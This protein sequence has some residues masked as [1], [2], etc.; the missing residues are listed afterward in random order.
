MTATMDSSPARRPLRAVLTGAAALSLCFLALAWNLPLRQIDWRQP[1]AYSDDGLVSAM[2]VKAVVDNGWYLH[3]PRLGAPEGLDLSDFPMSDNRFDVDVDERCIRLLALFT[4][5]YAL[6]ANS[7]FLLTFPLTVLTS[8]LVL[9]H[10]GISGGPAAAASVLFAFLP[11]HFFRGTHH[12]WLA[13]YYLVPPVVMVCLWVFPGLCSFRRPCS[14]TWSRR[15]WL[16]ALAICG[17][18]SSAGVYYA[19]FGVFLLGV[20]GLAAAWRTRSWAPLLRSLA[21]IAII[22][23]GVLANLLPTFWR[24]WHHG[25]STDSLHR[26]LAQA[27]YHGLKLSQLLLPV[28]EHPARALAELR[29]YYRLSTPLVNENDWTSLGLAGSA[30][31]LLLLCRLAMR[32]P[33]AGRPE[34]AD[35]LA[36]LN[37]A[38]FLL[39]TV[40]GLGSLIALFSPL[41]R[42]YNRIAVY[43]AFLSL[44][45]LALALDRWVR[46]RHTLGG[47]LLGRAVLALVLVGG[48]WD[49]SSRYTRLIF[50][51]PG[52]V[53]ASNREF[54]HAVESVLPAESLVF[55]LP[56][57]AFPESGRLH[58]MADYD[59]LRPYLHSRTLRWSHGAMSGRVG[60]VWQRQVTSKAVPEMLHDL[61]VAGFAGLYVDRAG[62]ADNATELESGLQQVLA[63]KPLVSRDRRLAFYDLREYSGQARA[64]YSPERLLEEQERILKPLV[65]QWAGGF[66]PLETDGNQT[67]RW[68]GRRGTLHI[69]NPADR[70]RETTL[71]FE[72]RSTQEEPATLRIEG[73]LLNE[74]LEVSP[75][76]IS[77]ART[78][79][80]PP[81]HHVL[82]FTCRGS[83]LRTPYD[84]RVLVFMVRN[85]R[86]M[87]AAVAVSAP[88]LM[89]PAAI[90]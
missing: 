58:N 42:A 45:M 88:F 80:V 14:E 8:L 2:Y 3:N 30:G 50:A 52:A 24:Q 16:A 84:A 23:V 62:F 11:Y 21:C 26:H 85:F 48:I 19:F 63:V 51:P 82:R 79:V 36:I 31:F 15:R 44:F 69:E 47:R 1:L 86:T 5:D 12:L 68:C 28:Y 70:P 73:P 67:W 89:Q 83:A 77:L 49:L 65:F 17:L 66:Y 41:I 72:L 40:G 57:K 60:D 4:D 55:Q 25:P 53:H 13:A 22:A 34:L 71:A 32:R 20:S 59:H 37:L 10:F 75:R 46:S 27:E 61:A 43:I 18:A 35:G 38:S 39:G 29:R 7:Y 81:G 78:I 76:E 54:V 33:A 6:I 56:Y 9:R 87:E 90:P 74:T 64:K